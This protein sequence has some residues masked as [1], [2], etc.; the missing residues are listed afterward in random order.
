MEKIMLSGGN[1]GG[2]EINKDQFSTE[3]I[4]EVQDEN[5]DIWVY[6]INGSSNPLEAVFIGIKSN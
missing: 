6:D 2:T 1:Y 5:D 3:G 4:Y